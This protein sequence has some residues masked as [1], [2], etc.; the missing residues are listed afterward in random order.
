VVFQW[1]DRRRG[2]RAKVMTLA[3]DEFIRR[4][5]LHVLPKGF[6]RIHH[7][8]VL[9]NRCRTPRVAACRRLCA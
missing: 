4:F 5:V 3:V 7:Y 1:R 9:G 6:I 8:G 2:N